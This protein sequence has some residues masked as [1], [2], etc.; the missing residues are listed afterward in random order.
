[1]TPANRLLLPGGMGDGLGPKYIS[2]PAASHG[3][4]LVNSTAA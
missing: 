3:D 1:M 2:A 4:D